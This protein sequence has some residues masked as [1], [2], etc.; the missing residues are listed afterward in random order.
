[1]AN[2]TKDESEELFLSNLKEHIE[3]LLDNL[4]DISAVINKKSSNMLSELETVTHSDIEVLERI[5]L[6][7][8]KMLNTCYLNVMDITNILEKDLDMVNLNRSDKL[9][10]NLC[11]K[12]LEYKQSRSDVKETISRGTQTAI[13]DIP[14]EHLEPK[15]EEREGDEEIQAGPPVDNIKKCTKNDIDMV[16][17]PGT[18]SDILN[19]H[20]EPKQENREGGEEVQAG[21]VDNIKKKYKNQY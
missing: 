20:L 15:Q 21:P 4:S 18:S 13:S 17:Q 9:F 10:K 1:M 11:S 5:G 8:F 2:S 16:S 6:R 12:I 7:M 14:N 3:Q 19:E